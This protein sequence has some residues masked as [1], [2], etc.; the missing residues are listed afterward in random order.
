MPQPWRPRRTIWEIFPKED[1]MNVH[2]VPADESRSWLE[3][4]SL[5][6]VENW[7]QFD[8]LAAKAEILR[9]ANNHTHP[10]HAAAS[11]WLCQNN[12]DYHEESGY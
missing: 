7:V 9:R 8:F 11:R 1:K 6:F 4:H 10:D 2:F 5:T 3:G 12:G